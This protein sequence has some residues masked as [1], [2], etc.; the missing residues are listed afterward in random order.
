M[1][2]MVPNRKVW[3]PVA[4]ATAVDGGKTVEAKVAMQFILKSPDDMPSLVEHANTID[5]Q[6]DSRPASVRKAALMGDL[7]ADWRDIGDEEKKPV[8]Y[9]SASLADFFALPGTFMA[10]VNAY[11]R[12]MAGQAETREKN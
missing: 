8:P 4:W 3:W 7:I 2:V 11:A 1:F 12:C 9:S 6:D 5:D 10:T